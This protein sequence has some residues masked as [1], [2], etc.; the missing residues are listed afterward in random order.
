MSE[1]FDAA[2]FR[3]LTLPAFLGREAGETL[4]VAAT[5]FKHAPMSLKA[6]EAAVRAARL[7][8]P[9][10]AVLAN[11][12]DEAKG[13]FAVIC[14]ALECVE[15]DLRQIP[16]PKKLGARGYSQK[17]IEFQGRAVLA[18][19]WLQKL[20]RDPMTLEDARA[21]VADAIPARLLGPFRK[22]AKKNTA[23]EKLAEWEDSFG[24]TTGRESVLR[25][26][27]LKSLRY[28]IWAEW[29]R[30]WREPQIENG[31]PVL[32]DKLE[33]AYGPELE[34]DWLDATPADVIAWLK[35]GA[36]SGC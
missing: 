10:L 28:E 12:P 13:A 9:N 31:K 25:Q 5:W 26:P 3:W 2:L 1:S 16:Q 8:L 30:C 15:R 20:E 23:G 22:G 36:C 34:R 14:E 4:D 32:N 24:R 7:A 21:V 11:A 17:D 27:V 6:R 18:V 29:Y 35:R 19:K 33:P